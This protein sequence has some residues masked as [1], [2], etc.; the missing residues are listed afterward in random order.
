MID[1]RVGRH[2]HRE[3]QELQEGGKPASEGKANEG[4]RGE[5]GG[6]EGG[7]GRER[8]TASHRPCRR[9]C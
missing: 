7:A 6:E 8:K 9:T 5:E 3:E 4:L 1:R 2:R